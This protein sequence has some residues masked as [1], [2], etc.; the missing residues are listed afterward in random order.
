METLNSSPDLHGTDIRPVPLHASADF[1]YSTQGRLD[2]SF[3]DQNTNHLESMKE[4]FPA[5]MSIEVAQRPSTSSHTSP[6]ARFAPQMET[7]HLFYLASIHR[8]N[9]ALN[10]GPIRAAAVHMTFANRFASGLNFIDPDVTKKL[11]PLVGR[12]CLDALV[13]T[14]I[15]SPHPD[16]DAVWRL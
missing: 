1:F 3:D 5:V 16:V 4:K 7:E 2:P 11:E 12:A 15:V 13:A 9:P 8:P 10:R 14:E 6:D